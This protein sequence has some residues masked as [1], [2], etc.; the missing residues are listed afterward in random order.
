MKFNKKAGLKYLGLILLAALVGCATTN[1]AD[2]GQ[3]AFV[4]EVVRETNR[5]IRLPMMIADGLRW[6]STRAER[7]GR[8]VHTYTLVNHT[9]AEIDAV[10]FVAEMR[11]VIIA[12]LRANAAVMQPLLDNR[13][14]IVYVYRDRNRREI[15]RIELTYQEYR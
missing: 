4:R 10:A 1:N 7:G 13:V 14:T 12:N 2:S 3:D 5:H 6:D 8:M 11:P 9:A 15:T